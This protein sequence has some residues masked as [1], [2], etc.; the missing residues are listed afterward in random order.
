MSCNTNS[1]SLPGV[2]LIAAFTSNGSKNKNTM[3]VDDVEQGVGVGYVAGYVGLFAVNHRL[4][5]AGAHQLA[6][7]PRHQC[8]R[9]D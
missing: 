7:H 2:S 9:R 8:P 1:G 4:G 5:R 6:G 3:A